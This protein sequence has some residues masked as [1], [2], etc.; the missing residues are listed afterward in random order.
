MLRDAFLSADDRFMWVFDPYLDER[1]GYFFEINPSG[2]MGDSLVGSGG[3]NERAWDG[4]WTAKVV[5]S[6]LGWVAEIEMPFRTLKHRPRC[7]G[8]TIWSK[9]VT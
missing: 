9:A 3:G 8:S 5:K 1:S 6:D 4:I 2:S 7:C